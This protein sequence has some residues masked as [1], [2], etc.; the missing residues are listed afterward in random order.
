MKKFQETG[1]NA[2]LIAAV[3]AAGYKTPTPIQAGAIPVIL[4]G[5]DLMGCAQTGTGKTAAFALPTLHRLGE[6]APTPPAPS[7]ARHAKGPKRP[8]RSLV[9]APTRELAAQIRDSFLTYGKASHLKVA[10]IFGGV[11]QTPQVKALEGGVDVVVATP[12]RLL[13]LMNQGYV[14]LS[15]VEVLILDEADQMLDMGFLPDL[16]RIVAKTPRGRQTLMFSATMP[17]P[18]QKLAEN[19]LRNPAHVR[20]APVSTPI[21]LVEQ[22]VYM[23][24]TKLK[25]QLLVHFLTAAGCTRTLVFTRTKHGADKVVKHLEKAGV[26]SSA[27]HG[28][29][30]Q[31]HRTRTLEAFRSNHAPVLVAT[32]IAARGLDIDGVS[33]VVNYDLPEVPET[34]VHRIGRTGRAGATGAATAFVAPDERSLLKAIERLTRMTVP[35]ANDHPTYT[36]VPKPAPGEEDR[37]PRGGQRG[38]RPS[39]G[40]PSGGRPSAVRSSAGGRSGAPKRAG[41]YSSAAST[42]PAPAAPAAPQ[43]KRLTGSR[44]T[45]RKRPAAPTEATLAARAMTERPASAAPT[46]GAPAKPARKRR[47]GRR[48]REKLKEGG[49]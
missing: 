2:T 36:A 17:E 9:L 18:I 32:D 21:E 20:V 6:S 38:G 34:Y 25:P 5:R 35:V 26:R 31:N 1:L 27:I 47:P 12:G 30:S 11:G 44:P 49:A 13:D 10:V 19:W 3:E 46:D 40:K 22:S 41:S 14:D 28:N 16:R 23:V 7:H 8:I 45:S 43:G 37:P 33:H 24:E 29:K 4:E 42:G 39:A 48:E 15:K